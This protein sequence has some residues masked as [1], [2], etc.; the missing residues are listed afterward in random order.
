MVT[1]YHVGRLI[2]EPECLDPHQGP[3]C[4]VK[5]NAAICGFKGL[6]RM[7][8]FGEGQVSQVRKCHWYGSLAEHHLRR[9]G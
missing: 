6:D 7:G 8:L 4:Q 2:L 3:M 9:S 1:P 5:G